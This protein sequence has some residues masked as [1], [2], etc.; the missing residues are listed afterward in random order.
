[1]HQ[2]LTPEVTPTNAQQ[3]LKFLRMLALKV[4][5]VILKLTT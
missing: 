5:A 1:V 2:G 4:D 3:G